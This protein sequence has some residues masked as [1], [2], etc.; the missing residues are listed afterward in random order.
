MT[1]ICP[2]GVQEVPPADVLQKEMEDAL[3]SIEFQEIEHDERIRAMNE[4]AII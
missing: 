1:A 3:Q 4:Q 2:G